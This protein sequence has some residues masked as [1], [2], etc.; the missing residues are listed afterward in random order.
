[1]AKPTDIP[2]WAT[3]ADY[4]AG[5]DAWSATPT[6]VEPSTGQKE[7]GW[8]PAQRPPAQYWNWWMNLVGQWLEYVDVQTSD[9][10]TEST[11]PHPAKM[12]GTFNIASVTPVFGNAKLNINTSVLTGNSQALIPIK[13]HHGKKV[14]NITIAKVFVMTAAESFVVTIEK[15]NSDGSANTVI[16]TETYNVNDGA[17]W[18]D[19]S[20]DF[21]SGEVDDTFTIDMRIALNS[22]DAGGGLANSLLIVSN[23]RVTH[24]LV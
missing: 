8:D 19:L 1:M 16:H 11:F 17:T 15:S 21:D 4:P 13:T 24:S 9:D 2:T 20:M 22:G 18:S 12:T 6:K 23:M 5:P 14:T 7:E 10:I 3:D